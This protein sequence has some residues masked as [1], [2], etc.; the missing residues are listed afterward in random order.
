MGMKIQNVSINASAQNGNVV[1][2]GQRGM[3]I[4]TFAYLAISA[5]PSQVCTWQSSGGG[6]L[7]GPFS[8]AQNGGACAPFNPKG[9]FATQP[10]EGLTLFNGIA[11]QVG[12]HVL[13]GYVNAVDLVRDNEYVTYLTAA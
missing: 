12:G 2:A 4:V 9:W 5:A 6:V 8:P 1:L 13:Y 10:G 7:G 3:C 11:Q